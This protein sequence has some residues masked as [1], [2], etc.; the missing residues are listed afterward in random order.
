MIQGFTK[1]NLKAYIQ[2]EDNSLGTVPSGGDIKYLFKFTNDMTGEVQYAYPTTS[3][4]NERY[5]S[6]N[7]TYNVTPNVYVGRINLLP[8]GYWKYQVFEVIW[9]TIPTGG[10]T[11]YYSNNMPPTEDF[12]FNPAA[13]DLGV[14]QGEVTKGKMYIEEK[15]GTEE[16]TYT[17]KAKSVQSL[18][19]EYGG[20]GYSTAPTITISAGGITTATATCT[21]NGSG[22][23]DTVTITNAGSGYTENPSVTISG[24]PTAPAV[25]TAEINQ[26]N[27]IYTG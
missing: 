8:A 15:V 20:T 17:Q 19:I 1:T 26:S 22:A 9:Q 7:F 5:G 3:T 27:Y 23:I 10:E 16:V 6:F 13:N 12:V 4:V 21:I 24:T 2:V 14:V 18:T 25:I 11:P